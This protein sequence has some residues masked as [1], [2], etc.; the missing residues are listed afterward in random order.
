VVKDYKSHRRV[1][2]LHDILGGFMSSR[3][4]LSVLKRCELAP[5]LGVHGHSGTEWVKVER[6]WFQLMCC[7]LLIGR[8]S[9]FRI[10]QS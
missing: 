5:L 10:G 1:G 6:T 8:S 9:Y 2:T 4:T 7:A 3:N